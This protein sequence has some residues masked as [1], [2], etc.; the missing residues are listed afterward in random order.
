MPATQ[1]KEKPVP[2][3][4]VKFDPATASLRTV[5]A[6][7]IGLYLGYA[8]GYCWVYWFK[9]GRDALSTAEHLIRVSK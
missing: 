7:G 9:L 6:Y 4:L 5:E 1:E 3:D 2:G 8:H